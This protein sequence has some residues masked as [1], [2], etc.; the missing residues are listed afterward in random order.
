MKLEFSQQIFEK[1]ANIKFHEILC[2]E[3]GVAA[4][5]QTEGRAER[6]DEGNSRFL[7]CCERVSIKAKNPL[8]VDYCHQPV[9]SSTL[10]LLPSTYQQL[11]PQTTAISL[12]TAQPSD[13]CHQPV[14]S[15]TLRLLPSACQQLSPQTTAIN[16]STAQPSE[17][18]NQP[19][20]S[21]ALRLLPSACQ[22]FNPPSHF[23]KLRTTVLF[24]S[25]LVSVSFVKSPSIKNARALVAPVATFPGRF[26]PHSVQKI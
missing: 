20:N 12:S 24:T 21:S 13:Y 25:H 22:R 16:L 1:S 17:Y 15:S 19:V 4:C 8:C 18:C 5:R 23:M 2:S 14:N 6:H 3:S 26:A 7:Q 10:R 11:N 9:N